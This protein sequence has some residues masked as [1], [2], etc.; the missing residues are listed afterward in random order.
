MK[1]LQEK[2][3]YVYNFVYQFNC[4]SHMVDW[5][6]VM[7]PNVLINHQNQ[8]QQSYRV[9]GDGKKVDFAINCFRFEHLLK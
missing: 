1:V 3:N 4:L 7:K 2:L 5:Q 9:L 8:H 6:Q